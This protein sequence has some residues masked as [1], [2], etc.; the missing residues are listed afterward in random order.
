VAT[1]ENIAVV[2]VVAVENPVVLVTF[3]TIDDTASG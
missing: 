2:A 3:T 1:V